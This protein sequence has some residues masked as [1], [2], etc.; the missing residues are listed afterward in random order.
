MLIVNLKVLFQNGV[1]KVKGQVSLNS[2][3]AVEEADS[4]PLGNRG[5]A[6]QVGVASR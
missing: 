2:V 1:G 6:F 5:Y 4:E 3:K